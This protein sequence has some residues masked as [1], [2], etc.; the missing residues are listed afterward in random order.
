[1]TEICQRAVKLAIR[2]S[3]EADISR[4]RLR[5]EAGATE[6]M[7]EVEDVDPVPFITATH[8]ESAMRDV[9]DSSCAVCCW[10][11]HL[12]MCVLVPAAMTHR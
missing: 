5:E 6:G 7:D 9:R 3:I 10:L 4:K 8:F 12:D 1:L 2:E 11:P